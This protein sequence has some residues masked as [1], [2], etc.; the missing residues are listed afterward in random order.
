MRLPEKRDQIR[1]QAS[2]KGLTVLES[3]SDLLRLMM[4]DMCIQS[5]QIIIQIF[6]AL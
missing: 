1:E 2:V 4:L 3:D 6:A 5:L